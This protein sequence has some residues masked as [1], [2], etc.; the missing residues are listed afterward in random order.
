MMVPPGPHQRIGRAS[1]NATVC[2]LSSMGKSAISRIPTMP[3][4]QLTI[5]SQSQGDFQKLTLKFT[6][7]E[8]HPSEVII[9]PL[10][11]TLG[12]LIKYVG[13]FPISGA[14]VGVDGDMVDRQ[15][16]CPIL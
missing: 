12:S 4:V 10:S 11:L 15:W 9:L 14:Y 3:A 6:L 16:P 13:T 5:K 8:K 7:Q 1:Q 2:F